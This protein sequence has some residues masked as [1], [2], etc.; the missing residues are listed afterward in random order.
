MKRFEKN[1]IGI[2]IRVIT[3][4]VVICILSILSIDVQAQTAFNHKVYVRGKGQPEQIPAA[5]GQVMKDPGGKKIFKIV[6]SSKVDTFKLQKDYTLTLTKS[7]TIK[8]LSYELKKQKLIEDDSP[9]TFN[10]KGV[11]AERFYLIR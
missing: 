9:M 1:P 4:V 6:E 3:F 11:K 2:I 7:K 10:K 8:G 5:V